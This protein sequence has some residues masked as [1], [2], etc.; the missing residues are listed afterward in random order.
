MRFIKTLSVSLA[1]VFSNWA[2]ADAVSFEKVTDNVY[3]FVGETDDRTKANLG[4]NANIGLVVT[5]E[6]AV[7][8]DSGA[9]PVSAAAIEKAVKKVTDQKV[10]AVINTGSQDHRWL[11]NDYF[12]QKGADIYAMQTTV[13]TQKE[14]L[15]SILNRIMG[16]DEIFKD[17]TPY[18][19]PKPFQG[20]EGQVEI[21]GVVFEVK[22]FN[23]AHFPGDA[24]VWL[25]QQKVLFTGD[26]VYLDRLLGIHPH[27][28]AVKWLDAF[29]QMAKLPADY[30]VPG[31]GRVADMAAAQAETGDYLKQLVGSVT[32][33]V[34][35]M[36]ALSDVTPSRDW[37]QFENLKHF[38]GWHGRNVSNT[39]QRLEMEMM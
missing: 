34:E 32:E 19:A 22:Y 29:D 5:N 10:V 23:D 4:L 27:T 7:V 20:N 11:G 28:H 26:H 21:G 8:I 30:V 24:V 15:N 12:A 18:H 37:S 39:F 3:A 14:M 38:Q 17:Q 36:G 9:G 2:M 35:N 31:H 16:T 25:P 33:T 6:G 13:D 1:M